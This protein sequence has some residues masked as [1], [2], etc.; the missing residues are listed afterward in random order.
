ME[1]IQFELKINYLMQVIYYL[2]S[3]NTIPMKQIYP[4]FSG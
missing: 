4:A 2:Y 1:H 3:K